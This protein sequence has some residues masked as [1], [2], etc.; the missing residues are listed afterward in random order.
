MRYS[1]VCYGLLLIKKTHVGVEGILNYG[2]ILTTCNV[3][4][5]HEVTIR[6]DSVSHLLII[7]IIVI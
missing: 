4:L 2:G 3:L 1:E 7:L 5:S 6:T